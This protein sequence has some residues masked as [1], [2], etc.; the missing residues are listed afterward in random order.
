MDSPPMKKG[1]FMDLDLSAYTPWIMLLFGLGVVWL[2]VSVVMKLAKT[3][4]S[5]GCSLLLVVGVVVL[6]VNLL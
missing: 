3:V 2:V 1:A 6:L 4:I 5:I